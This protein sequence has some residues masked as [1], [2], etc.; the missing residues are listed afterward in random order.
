MTVVRHHGGWVILLSI[1]AGYVLAVL[2]LPHW[3]ELIRPDWSALIII[4]WV[5]ALPQRVGVGV[6]WL[7]GLFQDALIGALLG[8]HALAF[9]LVAYLTLKLHQ[10]IRVFPLW[11]QALSVLVLLL[12]IRLILFWI[13]GLVGRPAPEW[14]FWTPAVIGTLVWPVV[15]VLLREMRRRYHVQ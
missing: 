3:M 8:T 5:L 7:V 15:F 13:N 4:Y 11:Q 10:R 6:A 12:L 14:I 9:A 1:I 2:P